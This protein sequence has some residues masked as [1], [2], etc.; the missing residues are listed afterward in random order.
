M[1]C[2]D[3]QLAGGIEKEDKLIAVLLAFTLQDSN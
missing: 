3:T 1:C 2:Y